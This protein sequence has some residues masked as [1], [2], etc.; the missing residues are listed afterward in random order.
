[1]L[2]G[3]EFFECKE[4]SDDYTLQFILDVEE[5]CFYRIFHP[6]PPKPRYQRLWS[7]LKCLLGYKC[8]YG[9]QDCWI[10]STDE[11]HE[12]ITVSEI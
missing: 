4:N 7:T 12:I 1:M 8:K 9:H 6:N 5:N 3:I 10:L 11:V 2:D